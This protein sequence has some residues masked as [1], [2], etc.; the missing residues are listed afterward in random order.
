MCTDGQK[1]NAFSLS[2]S[3]V[4]KGV[5]SQRRVEK[6]PKL[7]RS[8]PVDNGAT[9]RSK[10]HATA[11][12]GT[13]LTIQTTDQ[14]KAVHKAHQSS[15]INHINCNRA[16]WIAS[17]IWALFSAASQCRLYSAGQAFRSNVPSIYEHTPWTNGVSQ[18]ESYRKWWGGFFSLLFKKNFSACIPMP[19]LLVTALQNITVAPQGGWFRGQAG[20]TEWLLRH[21]RSMSMLWLMAWSLERLKKVAF[22]V[23]FLLGTRIISTFENL[24]GP[25]KQATTLYGSRLPAHRVMHCLFL[26]FNLCLRRTDSNL[27][28][29]IDG[30]YALLPWV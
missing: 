1:Q 4:K 17:S 21:V 3:L 11:C 30:K 26:C 24:L 2:Q 23:L 10:N 22:P 5:N 6:T 8:A 27:E 15:C 13:I 19:F 29:R 12:R 9:T 20:N 14:M 16:K 25:A 7:S 18:A 28:P